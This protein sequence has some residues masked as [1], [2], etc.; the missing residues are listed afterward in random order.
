MCAFTFAERSSIKKNN[1][2][3]ILKKISFF[4]INHSV[5]YPKEKNDSFEK[6]KRLTLV[7]KKVIQNEELNKQT[8]F[9]SFAFEEEKEEISF[10]NEDD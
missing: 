4:F 3:K 2:V 6:N 7:T 5:H 9:I 8:Y 1:F 10:F